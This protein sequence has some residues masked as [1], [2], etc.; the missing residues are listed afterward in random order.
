MDITFND[1][2]TANDFNAAV[3]QMIEQ[4]SKWEEQ[5]YAKSNRELYSILANCLELYQAC[6]ANHSLADGLDQAMKALEL[7]TNAKT[8]LAV[9]VIRLIFA[10]KDTQAKIKNRIYVY[11]KALDVAHDAGKSKASFADF[12]DSKGGLDELRRTPDT[13]AKTERDSKVAI[14]KN[15][16]ILEPAKSLVPAF[17]LPVQLKPKAGK[18]FSV[19]LIVQNDDGTGQ[20]VYGCV[21]DSIVQ[22]VLEEAGAAI[23]KSAQDSAAAE[24]EQTAQQ[25][26]ESNFAT[27][28]QQLVSRQLSNSAQSDAQQS[29]P[30]LA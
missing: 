18:R 7:K 14:A 5:A 24:V 4:R 30:V 22:S 2:T 16:Y 8:S 6:I 29:D 17:E 3:A 12:V 19:G 21:T 27:F 26:S 9:K 23:K 15:K 20:I 25:Q 1:Q 13:T 28:M 10:T 11:A